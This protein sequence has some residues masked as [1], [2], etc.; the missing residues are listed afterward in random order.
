[1]TL[2]SD[3]LPS[4][5]IPSCTTRADLRAA[6]WS[7]SA[8]QTAFRRGDFQQSVRGL[9]LPSDVADD[10]H[11]RCAAALATQR[12]DAAISRRTAAVIHGFAW[13][14]DAWTLPDRDIDVTVA[15]DDLTRSARRG[16]DRRIADLP[17]DDVVVW[18]GLRVTSPA[19]TAVD[20]ARFEK[21]RLFAVQLLDGV[22][23]FEHCTREEMQAVLERMVR[24]P[25]VQRGR[26][27]LGMAR[28]GVDSPQ[29]TTARLHIVDGGLP[30]P[31]V[32]LR[33]TVG[34][35]DLAQGDL[36]YWKWLIWIEYDGIEVHGPLRMD[37]K[38]QQKDRFL[39]RRGWEPF[40]LTKADNAMPGRFLRE[41]S[42]AIKEAP[43]RIAAM[44]PARSPEVRAARLLLGI[45]PN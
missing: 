18:R 32:N 45:D 40:R 10:L 22:L 37:G 43:A 20:V 42:I 39:S 36:G 27:R 26:D 33:I 35:I 12:C 5:A 11:Q 23:R 9:W 25:H 3:A 21:S 1:M 6:G 19:R 13:L 34:G 41:L 2:P 30:H 15:R 29:E 7:D 8:I 17:A 14:P 44:D 16:M 38:D 28:E 31:D 4:G 24:V